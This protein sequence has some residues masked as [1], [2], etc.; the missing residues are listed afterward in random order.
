MFLL[1]LKKRKCVRIVS[2]I[3]RVLKKRIA[4]VLR[5]VYNKSCK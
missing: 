4:I 5:L 2:E 1:T 3:C